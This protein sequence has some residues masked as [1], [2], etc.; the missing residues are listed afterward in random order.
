[1]LKKVRIRSFKAIEDTEDI[2]L[3]PLNVFIGRNGSGKSSVLEFLEL[4]S[5]TI[6]SDLLQA[7]VPFRRGRDVI[8][9]WGRK[10]KNQAF[11]KL[12]FD[13]G[14]V[15]AGDLLVYELGIQADEEGDKLG[16]SY[17][18]L[19][20]FFGDEKSEIIRTGDN[21][22]TCR[23]PIALPEAKP[24]SHRR[25]TQRTK[26][27]KPEYVKPEYQWLKLPDPI[28]LGLAV[29]DNSLS[30]GGATLKS[31]LERS[32]FLRLSPSAVADFAPRWRR[33]GKKPIDPLGQQTAELL[34]SLS[35]D[36]LEVL[37]DKLKYVTEGFS[38]LTSHRPAGPADQRYF[39]LIEGERGREIEVP[40]WVLSE[41]TRRLTALLAVTLLEPPPPL[42]TIEE[43]ENGFDPWTLQ[44]LLTE[45]ASQAEQGVQILLTTHS[46]FLMNLLPRQVFHFVS[47][48]RGSPRFTRISS[49]NTRAVLKQM[50]VGDAYTGNLLRI[51]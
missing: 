37:V 43:V 36:A 14:D 3:E 16:V 11:L 5:N 9:N 49:E 42:I 10:R 47:R 35:D 39:Q 48:E 27:A 8:H 32:V 21:I 23:V 17:E 19:I 50:R 45:L 24:V 7:S 13:P 4:V 1:M 29:L 38:G 44:F 22:R 28:A 6:E 46:P 26:N 33:R 41:G 12:D 20:S 30:K 31:F 34:A 25:S 18:S 51:K 15:S 40:A 2:E